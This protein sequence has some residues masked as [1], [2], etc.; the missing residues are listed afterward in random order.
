MLLE[1]KIIENKTYFKSTNRFIGSHMN[2]I[3]QNIKRHKEKKPP[4]IFKQF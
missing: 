3:L 4:Y 2:Y 1:T